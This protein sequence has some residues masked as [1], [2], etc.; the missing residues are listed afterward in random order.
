MCCKFR[1]GPQNFKVRPFLKSAMF[2]AEFSLKHVRL[3]WCKSSP[4]AKFGPSTFSIQLSQLLLSLLIK[5]RLK[6]ATFLWHF[7]FPTL[8]FQLYN[9]WES[10]TKDRPD[11]ICSNSWWA[12]SVGE[13]RFQG[14]SLRNFAKCALIG[15][16]E[17]GFELTDFTST[18]KDYAGLK[19]WSV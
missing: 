4:Q 5:S 3:S 8:S 18:H 7:P 19:K 12:L 13:V 15:H 2:I 10:G 14:L 1:F 16:R 9:I 6:K 11:N 17:S